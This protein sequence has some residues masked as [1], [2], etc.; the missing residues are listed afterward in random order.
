MSLEQLTEESWSKSLDSYLAAWADWGE[1]VARDDKP[2]R[3][4][5]GLAR[6]VLVDLAVHS[7]ARLDTGDDVHGSDLHPGISL[8]F[9][10]SPVLRHV[11]FGLYRDKWF[12]QMLIPFIDSI[13]KVTEE[14]WEDISAICRLTHTE[15]SE[16]GAIPVHSPEQKRLLRSGRSVHY[17]IV[18]NYL[19]RRSDP[20]SDSD[21]IGIL[22]SEVSVQIP[23]ATSLDT[24]RQVFRKYYRCVRQ[25]YRCDYQKSKGGKATWA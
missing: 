17:R 14:F 16:N 20:T 9:S 6:H 4:I 13:P 19:L 8:V 2:S 15:F 3:A 18:R 1:K 25:L 23:F 5:N 21:D 7:R 11:E 12:V 24:L 22:L 10:S